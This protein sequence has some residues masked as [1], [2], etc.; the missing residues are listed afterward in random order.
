MSETPARRSPIRPAS[1]RSSASVRRRRSFALFLAV[2]ALVTATVFV[3]RAT[4]GG[5]KAAAGKGPTAGGSGSPS[6]SH[7]TPRSPTPTNVP[8]KHIIFM[9]KENRTYDQYF[10]AYPFGDGATTGKKS[11]GTTVQLGH[12]PDMMP[13]DLCHAFLDGIR[14]IDH[15]KMDGLD[16]ICREEDG[17]GY[18]QYQ[19]EDMPA[20]WGY[21]DRFVL[22]DR[23]FTSMYGP[24]FPEHLYVIAAQSNLIVGNKNTVNHAGSYCDDPTEYAPAFLHGLAADQIAEIMSAESKFDIHDPK[25]HDIV[26]YWHTVRNCFDIKTLP[27]ELE[28]AGVDWKYYADKDIWMNAMQAIKHVRFGPLW[29]KVVDPDHFMADIEAGNLPSVS[30][31]IPPEQYNEHPGGTSLCAG[32]NWTVEQ[33]NAL[34]K[35]KYWKDSLV[36][37]VWDDFGGTYDHVVPPHYDIMGL[38]PRT[39]AL[40]ISPYTKQGKQPDGGSVDSTVYEFSSVL[41]TIEQLHGL[42]ALTDRD[43]KANSLFNALDFTKPPNLAPKLF[44]YNPNCAA[45]A[46]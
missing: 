15:G 13:H 18:T 10:G 22:S 27:D 39:P 9:V 36:V 7:P 25:L 28:N 45:P 2:V 42:K 3:V 12:A 11:D 6:G 5:K 32:E 1:H 4:V 19:R 41:K 33:M 14:V 40:I 20:Y 24:T 31:L 44:D 21:A 23:F 43:R 17:S 29:N 37:I 26:K 35:S 34:M 46:R 30:W 8:I 38:G 16:T